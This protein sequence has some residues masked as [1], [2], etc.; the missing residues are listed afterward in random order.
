M[1]IDEINELA[2]QEK[3]GLLRKPKDAEN[4]LEEDLKTTE[5]LLLNMKWFVEE[6][7]AQGFV[8]CAYRRL[9]MKKLKGVKSFK[10]LGTIKRPY[11][12]ETD[13]GSG[14]F[15]DVRKGFNKKM[16]PDFVEQNFCYSNCLQ[17]A[18]TT[19]IDCKIL[20][21]IGY[22]EKPFLHSVILINDRVIDF[23]YHVVVDKDLYVSLTKFE[24]MVELDAKK[25]REGFDFVT[26]KRDVLRKS[27]L[28][29]ITINFAYDD[30]LDYLNNETRQAE[31]PNLGID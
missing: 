10:G 20:S 17:F 28:Q 9:V 6:E 27:K 31:K 11:K 26:S 3:A 5:Q 1:K 16:Y 4:M 23:N 24:T 19:K 15:Y 30:V 2:R 12:I 21:G 22:M 8:G 14:S 25:V 7:K 18:L 13:F 29:T